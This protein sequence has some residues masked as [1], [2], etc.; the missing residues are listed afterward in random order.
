VAS[1]EDV[2]ALIGARRDAGL[3]FDVERFV[4]PISVRPGAITFEPAPGAPEKLAHRL[5]SQLKAWTGQTWLVA[6]ETSGGGPTIRELRD[7]AKAEVRAGVEAD[8]FVRAVL[9]TFPGAEIVAVRETPGA[10]KPK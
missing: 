3:Q 6:T 8:P 7:R 10:P 9:D 2:V 4:K 5:S 1:F